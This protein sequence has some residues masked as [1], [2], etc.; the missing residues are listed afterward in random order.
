MSNFWT[1]ILASVLEQSPQV[2]LNRFLALVRV[3]NSYGSSTN[4]SGTIT[5][6]V[7]DLQSRGSYT[8]LRF[9]NPRIDGRFQ[10]VY[11]KLILC[12]RKIYREPE[13]IIRDPV[14]CS[15]ELMLKL[16]TVRWRGLILTV[17]KQ[18]TRYVQ[19]KLQHRLAVCTIKLSLCLTN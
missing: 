6:Q 10:R 17:G 1:L 14:F 18:C 9:W 5:L 15:I 7:T 4:D 12:S 2:S 13:S 11:R 16:V 3:F 19:S 8:A